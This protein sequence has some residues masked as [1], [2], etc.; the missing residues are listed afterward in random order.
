MG[1]DVLYPLVADRIFLGCFTYLFAS[2]RLVSSHFSN[3]DVF[4]KQT[5]QFLLSL[6]VFVYQ[7]TL[8]WRHFIPPSRSF[9]SLKLMLLCM[10]KFLRAMT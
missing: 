4:V 2:G 8:I 1:H 9:I 6:S 7:A 5:S 10:V 3:G